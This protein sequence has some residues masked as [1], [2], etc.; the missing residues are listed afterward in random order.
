MDKN[1]LTVQ[2]LITTMNLETPKR[3][4]EDLNIQTSFVIGNQANDITDES[5]VFRN[6]SGIIATRKE[7]GVGNN[8]NIT[9]KYSSADICVLSDDDMRFVDNYEQVVVRMYKMLPG[10][11]VIIFNLGNMGTGG[12]I[13]KKTKKL[14]K[15][16]YMN[17][18]AAR[19]TFRRQ[20]VS[21]YGISFNTNFGGGCL[22]SAGEDSLFLGD[23]LDKR[24]S[25]YV[26]PVAIA[27][28]LDN[29]ESTWFN[30]YTDKF[31]FDKGVFLAI[32]S[33]RLAK[34]YALYFALRHPEY[35]DGDRSVYEVYSL[36]CK[37]IR[38]ITK[39]EYNLLEAE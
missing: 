38:Y 7:K 39:K 16:N 35:S 29:R 20:S 5:F 6:N 10:A 17:Y 31:L 8:R 18:G 21:Y 13:T 9:F 1:E 15:R 3:L 32:A 2:V 30:G 4:L 36:I 27:S 22:H 12:R 11:D 26:V 14:N 19:I 37:G 28:L 24:L 25:V 34:I 33:S 23:C